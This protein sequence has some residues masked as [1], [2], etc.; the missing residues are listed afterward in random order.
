MENGSLGEAS[1]SFGPR[2][3]QRPGRVWGASA[4]GVWGPRE[5]V[6]SSA[7]QGGDRVLLAVLPLVLDAG[8]FPHCIPQPAAHLLCTCYKLGYRRDRGP[9]TSALPWGRQAPE[10]VA[11]EHIYWLALSLH[12][13]RKPR[14]VY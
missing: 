11:I 10:S 4:V 12:A 6:S 8:V 9:E 7:S 3:T 5:G 13:R 2:K 1:L 14:R